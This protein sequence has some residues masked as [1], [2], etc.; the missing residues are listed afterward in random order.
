[1]KSLSFNRTI[2]ELKQNE[3]WE[4]DV[5]GKTFNRTILELKP[6]GNKRGW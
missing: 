6:S 1:M 4:D 3:E 2:L 5:P